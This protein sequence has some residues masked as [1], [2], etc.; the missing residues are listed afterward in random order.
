MGTNPIFI[1][2]CDDGSY[3]ACTHPDQVLGSYW[4]SGFSWE[5]VVEGTDRSVGLGTLGEAMDDIK[6]AS[7]P[8]EGA[9]FGEPVA[10]KNGYLI[11]KG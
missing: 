7:N 5:A 4:L 2:L 9:V 6:G 11:F 3:A 8:P 10:P 1:I